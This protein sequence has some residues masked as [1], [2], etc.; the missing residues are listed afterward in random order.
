MIRHETKFEPSVRDSPGLISSA[1]SFV[2]PERPLLNILLT[3]LTSILSALRVNFACYKRQRGL[4]FQ[5]KTNVSEIESGEI[6]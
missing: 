3:Y 6:L 4:N 1:G 5:H 2:L